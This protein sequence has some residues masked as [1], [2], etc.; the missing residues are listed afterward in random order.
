MGALQ[1][2]LLLGK[3][4]GGRHGFL[5]LLFVTFVCLAGWLVDWQDQHQ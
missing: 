1:P 2:Q 4:M 5:L 3:M